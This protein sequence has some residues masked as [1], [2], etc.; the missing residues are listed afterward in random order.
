L[1][2]DHLLI[3]FFQR[4]VKIP[5]DDGQIDFLQNTELYLV[6]CLGDAEGKIPNI[7]TRAELDRFG[8][9]STT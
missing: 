9:D 1:F 2:D 3:E 6:F 5:R 8:S 4:S 7:L